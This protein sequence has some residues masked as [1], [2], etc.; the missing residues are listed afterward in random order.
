M[1][2]LDNVLSPSYVS[3]IEYECH[4]QKYIYSVQTSSKTIAYDGPV[5]DTA[6][7]HDCGQLECNL[8]HPYAQPTPTPT[9]DF[10]KPLVYTVQDIMR[11]DMT[12]DTLMRAKIN[13]MWQKETFPEDH[14]NVVHQDSDEECVSMIYYV[15]D[16][17]GDTY[18]FNEFYKK[19]VVPTLTIAKRVTPK[20]N[21]VVLFDSRRYHASSNPRNSRDR[22]VINFVFRGK[23]NEMLQS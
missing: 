23:I 3:A 7:T 8:Y 11:D 2:V 17:D 13:I 19:D 9:F 21:R 14:W 15:N 20:K 22:I 5:L 4:Q 6:N 1:I 16:T 18:L 10:L 12:L